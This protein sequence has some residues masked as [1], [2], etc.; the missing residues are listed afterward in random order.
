MSVVGLAKSGKSFMGTVLPSH[1]KLVRALL[2][3]LN[4]TEQDSLSRLCCKL[5][6]SDLLGFATEF[7]YEDGE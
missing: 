4:A 7:M 5:R 6:E 2:R 1:S 3:V